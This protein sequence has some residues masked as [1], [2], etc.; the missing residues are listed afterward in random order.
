[1]KARIIEPDAPEWAEVL[2]ATRHDVYHL[3]GYVSTSAPADGGRAVALFVEESADRRLLIPLVL[4][5]ASDDLTDATSPYGYP[6][7]LVTGEPSIAFVGEAMKHGI[8]RLREAGVVSLFIRLHPLITVDGLERVGAVVPHGEGVIID[9]SLS[10][11]ELWRQTRANHRRDINRSTRSGHTFAFETSDGSYA[12]FKRLYLETMQRLSASDYY[13]FDD[14]YFESLRTSL[15][16]HL[17]LAIVRIDDEIAA[18]AL[19][20]SVCGIVQLHL[21]GWD[22][23]LARQ[24]PTKLLYHQV[25]SWARQRGDRWMNLG[26]GLGSEEDSL[27]HFK[28]GFSPLTRTFRSLRVIVDTRE[29]QRLVAESD[30]TPD[31]TMAQDYFPAYRVAIRQEA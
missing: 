1:M 8:A 14:A 28:L 29:Y 16:D 22:D 17:H 12:T 15:G 3:P 11:E 4:R 21:A 23:G 31:P 13:M 6:G 27:L 19:F 26:G 7:P 5:A 30:P 25:R 24:S 10:E 9:L 18:A 20:T 2:A